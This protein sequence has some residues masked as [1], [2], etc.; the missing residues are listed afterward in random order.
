MSSKPETIISAEKL[1]KIMGGKAFRIRENV[2]RFLASE[3]DAKNQELFRIY[4]VMKQLLVYDDILH[5]QEITKSIQKTISI[6]KD[7]DS[8]Y[9]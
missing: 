2:Q 6:M 9:I 1:A 7:I 8:V 5:Y 4:N 3:K